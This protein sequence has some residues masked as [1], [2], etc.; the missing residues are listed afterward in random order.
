MVRVDCLHRCRWS[1][2]GPSTVQWMVQG[3]RFYWGGTIYSMTDHFANTRLKT[4]L[5]WSG[6]HDREHGKEKMEME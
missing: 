1:R 6:D 3:N 5:C 2:G 4:A